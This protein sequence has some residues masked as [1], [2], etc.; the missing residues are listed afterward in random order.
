MGIEGW[1]YLD[2]FMIYLSGNGENAFFPLR[3]SS[4]SHYRLIG[5]GIFF[6]LYRAVSLLAAYFVRILFYARSNV[7]NGGWIKWTWVV[8]PPST[9]ACNACFLAPPSYILCSPRFGRRRYLTEELRFP[10]Q[11]ERFISFCAS[12]KLSTAE[13]GN[14]SYSTIFWSD[15]HYWISITIL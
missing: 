2:Y 1:K 8:K 10:P 15:K 11:S 9:W 3:P 12:A 5:N 14:I 4:L 13:Y 7:D 6:R